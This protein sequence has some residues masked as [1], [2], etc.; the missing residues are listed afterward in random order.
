MDAPLVSVIVITYNQEHSLP[1]AL[2]SI[3]S[4]ECPFGYEIIVGEDGSSD[5]TKDV[6]QSYVRRYPKIIAPIFQSENQGILKNFIS[7]ICA[8]RGKYIAFCDGDDY[9]NCA[10]KLS[11]QV[12]VLEKQ[13]EYGLVYTDV[14][15]DSKIT[16]VKYYRGMSHPSDNLF[17]Q[18][19]KGNIIVS[20]SVCL[21]SNLLKHVDFNAFVEQQFEMEDYPMWLALSLHTQFY[22]LQEATVSYVVERAVV[23]SKEVGRHA[24]RFDEKTTKIRLYFQSKYP[25]RTELTPDQIVDDHFFLAVRAGLNMNDRQ[26]TLRYLNK[27][28]NPTAYSKR[29]KILCQTV[30]GFHLYQFYRWASSKKKTQLQQYFGM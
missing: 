6:L 27:I 20:S 4:Q 23:N 1:V 8:A 12:A 3:L 26:F 28:H 17:S 9:W 21:R 10:D 19:L 5:H 18:L 13:V 14:W 25:E 16:G 29:L 22:Y 24:V 2:D 7:C 11:K 30:V 15:M